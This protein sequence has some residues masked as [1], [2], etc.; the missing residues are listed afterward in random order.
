MDGENLIAP[1]VAWAYDEE[2]RG[3][4]CASMSTCRATR[5]ALTG[6]VTRARSLGEEPPKH[7]ICIQRT[8]EEV[9]FMLAPKS[10][11]TVHRS[12]VI[13]KRPHTGTRPLRFFWIA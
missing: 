7:R 8:F 5:S 11:Q 4:A 2:G 13:A 3:A 6:S 10:A 1:C 12:L 9:L